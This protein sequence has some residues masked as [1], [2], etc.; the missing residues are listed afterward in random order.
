MQ[1]STKMHEKSKVPW[2]VALAPTHSI[3]HNTN[4]PAGELST[5]A[6]VVIRSAAASLL[7]GGYQ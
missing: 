5:L 3:A 2:Q 1:T 6:L 4:R 7:L